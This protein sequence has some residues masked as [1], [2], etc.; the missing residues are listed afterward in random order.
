MDVDRLPHLGGFDDSSL[1]LVAS[2]K[3]DLV[4]VERIFSLGDFN[5][6]MTFGMS[7]FKLPYC[8]FPAGQAKRVY[9]FIGV[10]YVPVQLASPGQAN[11]VLRDVATGFGV[12]VAE[13]I[14][15]EA[16]FGVFVLAL[17]AEGAVL[18]SPH[19]L[20]HGPVAI[21]LGLSGFDANA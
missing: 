9:P 13:A 18:C 17:V 15:I 1:A 2:G 14:V 10:L 5:G 20:A 8:C 19:S 7:V 12:V 3:Y 21:E 11:R 4:R 16:S 6:I